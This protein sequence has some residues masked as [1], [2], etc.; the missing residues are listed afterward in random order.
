VRNQNTV[1]LSE[2]D[3][4]SQ[5]GRQMPLVR[6]RGTLRVAS[7]ATAPGRDGR[8]ATTIVAC[9]SVAMVLLDLTVVNVALDEISTDLTAPLSGVQWIVNG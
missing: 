9:L 5:F 3:N 4:C 1:T 7:E 6:R 2:N 8:L